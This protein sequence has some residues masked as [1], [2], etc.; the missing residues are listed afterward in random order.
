MLIVARV[1]T[2]SSVNGGTRH[3]KGRLFAS[4]PAFALDQLFFRFTLSSF[5]Y[6]TFGRPDVGALETG[7]PVPFA[8]AFDEAQSI[9]DGRFTK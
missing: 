8:E 6:M 1:S 5:S 7:E 9:M 4:A 3:L 2:W